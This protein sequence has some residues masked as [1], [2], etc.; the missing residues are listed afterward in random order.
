MIRFVEPSAT[1]SNKRRWKKSIWWEDFLEGIEPIQL[2]GKEYQPNLAKTL[3]WVEKSTLTAIKGLSAIAKKENID[4]MDLV[5]NS[6]KYNYDRIDKMVKEYEGLSKLEKA[7]F[8]DCLK[9]HD[10][11][12]MDKKKDKYVL[13]KNFKK[14]KKCPLTIKSIL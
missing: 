3:N 14:K 1:D 8:I 11:N 5:A 4:F 13:Y 12:V 6:D 2:K 7:R 9:V 10:I